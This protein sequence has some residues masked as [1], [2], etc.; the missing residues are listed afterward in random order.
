MTITITRH[1]NPTYLGTFTEVSLIPTESLKQFRRA[2]VFI[3]IK[4]ERSM[5]Y[6]FTI[7]MGSISNDE[8]IRDFGGHI[9]AN[10]HPLT[11]ALRE[12]QEESLG[13][14]QQ[15]IKFTEI[16]NA[17]VHYVADNLYMFITLKDVPIG[18]VISE[19]NLAKQNLPVDAPDC[20]KETERIVCI[21]R[22]DILKKFKQKHHVKDKNVFYGPSL[23][24]TIKA[25]AFVI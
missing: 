13:V 22:F 12:L 14:F 15:Y 8:F 24:K 11:A 20:M 5:H 7:Q 25:F 18:K 23:W 9:E 16:V 2:G 17:P 4:R 10:E 21:N 19:F 3:R 6:L 1:K